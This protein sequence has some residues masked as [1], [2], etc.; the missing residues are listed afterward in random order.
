MRFIK[1]LLDNLYYTYNS[2]YLDYF[3]TATSHVASTKLY[4]DEF[5]QRFRLLDS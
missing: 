3:V 5:R 1:K 2:I 4:E